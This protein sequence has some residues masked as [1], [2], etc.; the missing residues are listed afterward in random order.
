MLT[1]HRLLSQNSKVLDKSRQYDLGDWNVNNGNPLDTTWT[2]VWEGDFWASEIKVVVTQVLAVGT[3]TVDTIELWANPDNTGSISETSL[4]TNPTSL[5]TWF[6]VDG[7]DQ[8]KLRFNLRDE[9]GAG[10]S[11]LATREYEIEFWG[12]GQ[13]RY[14]LPNQ[15]LSNDSYL[16]TKFA[17]FRIRLNVQG[18]SVDGFN[19][20]N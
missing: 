19:F 12:R 7:D 20:Q 16:E 18:E 15:Q 2:K 4:Y 14:R 9:A 6:A 13:S 10:A 11:V 5:N 17:S 8:P 1:E 3:P